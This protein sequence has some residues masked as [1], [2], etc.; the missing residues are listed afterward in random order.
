MR[1]DS[2]VLP[3]GRRLA[4]TRVGDPRGRPVIHCHGG[5]SCRLEIAF[6][7]DLCKRLGLQWIAVDRPGIGGSD[8]A[9]K[10]QP[11]TF[12]ADVDALITALEIDRVAISGWSAGGP[13][14]LICAARR[15]ER[16]YQ[17][18]TLAGMAPLRND[19]DVRRLGMA[20]DRL[21]FSRGRGA[22]ALARGWLEAVRHTPVP[23]LR[24]AIARMQ[25][26]GPD[27]DALPANM[28]AS[29]ATSLHDSLRP[30]VAGTLRD[31][32]LLR[33]ADWSLA[34]LRVPVSIWHG[35]SDELLPVDHAQRLAAMI[36]DAH[37]YCVPDVGHFLPQRQLESIFCTALWEPE[38]GRAR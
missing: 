1:D 27:G 31:Y 15:P 2:L 19:G 3:D 30:G 14:A 5:L 29:V 16:F 26:A 20:T 28:A 35:D 32:R 33:D 12:P 36:P 37:L 10:G 18:L 38:P 23:L 21:L 25:R 24:P 9:R 13:W 8:P 7:D 4:F 22:R 6:A 11:D 17:V 34:D